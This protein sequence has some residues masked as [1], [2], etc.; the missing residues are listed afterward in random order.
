MALGF[1]GAGKHGGGDDPRLALAKLRLPEQSWCTTRP[2][3]RGGSGPPV[4]GRRRPFR[5][6]AAAGCDTVVVA[7]KPQACRPPVRDLPGRCAREDV[8]SPSWRGRR[9]PSSRRRSGKARRSFDDAPTRPAADSDGEHR[10]YFPPVV[11]AATRQEVLALSPPSDGRPRCPARKLLD[12]V[13]ALSGS[14]PPSRFS[15][16]RRWRSG[17]VRAGMGRAEASLLAAS[18]LEERRGWSARR[19]APRR[20]QD[21]GDVTGGDHGR[22][23]AALERGLPGTVMDAVLSAWQRCRE[24]SG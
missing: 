19:E 14:V 4:R 13:T 24:L 15:S 10:V 5:R 22:G 18:T 17:A 8:S 1:L 6:G 20:T 21:H 7:V 2:G 12:A 16:R 11:D 23:V 9:S 3:S